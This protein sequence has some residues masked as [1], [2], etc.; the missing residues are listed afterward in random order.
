MSFPISPMDSDAA[1][2]SRL[3]EPEVDNLLAEVAWYLL[4]LGFLPA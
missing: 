3:I 2:L 1:I 4:S